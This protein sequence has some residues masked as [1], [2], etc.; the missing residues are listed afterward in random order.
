[1]IRVRRRYD[2]F[3]F[4]MR[5]AME[6]ILSYT[7]GKSYHDFVNDSQLRDAVTRNFE[8]LGESVKH[9]P[10]KFQKRYKNVPWQHMYSLRNFIVHEYF[11]MDEEILWSI[12]ENDLVQNLT[13]I[14]SIIETNYK[15]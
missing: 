2:F 6:N 10:F 8:I 14:N 7:Q 12:I 1:M 15:G 11:D 13:D 4:D 3:I 9:I 5:R